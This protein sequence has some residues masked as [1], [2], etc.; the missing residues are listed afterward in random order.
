M[1][2][3]PQPATHLV[4]LRGIN[5]GGNQL[6]PMADLRAWLIRQGFVNPRSLLQS[7]NLVLGSPKLTGS[8]LEEALV[9]AAGVR[10]GFAPEFFVRTAEEWQTMIDRNPLGDL[11]ASDPSRFLVHFFK[12]PIAAGQLRALRAASKGKEQFEVREREMYVFYPDGIARP[13]LTQAMIDRH[14]EARG[15]ARNWNTVMKLAALAQS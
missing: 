14:L 11:A 13:G 1:N 3:S 9:K 5:V 10:F 7:G 8:A 12:R 2:S 15:T 6:V 4:L